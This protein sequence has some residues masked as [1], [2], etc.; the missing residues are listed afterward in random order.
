MSK[1][2]DGKRYIRGKEVKQISV[3]VSPELHRRIKI[4][5]IDRD[6]S[7]TKLV[8]SLVVRAFPAKRKS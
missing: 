7:V 8:H 2:I 5:A 6:T 1:M 4:A 3:Y